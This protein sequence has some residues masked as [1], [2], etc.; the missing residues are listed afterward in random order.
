MTL[1]TECHEPRFITHICLFSEWNNQCYYVG[2]GHKNFIW[3]LR[4]YHR[5]NKQAQKVAN[6]LD[7][8]ISNME[9][10]IGK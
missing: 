3:H 1:T 7:I 2:D 5:L 4:T 8:E 9:A 10:L 6:E